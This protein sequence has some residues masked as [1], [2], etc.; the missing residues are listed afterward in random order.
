MVLLGLMYPSST[1]Y[2]LFMDNLL[3]FLILSTSPNYL[4]IYFEENPRTYV[5]LDTNVLMGIQR[6][7]DLFLTR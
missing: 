7:R 4:S 5:I 1:L 3:K 2:F 6:I